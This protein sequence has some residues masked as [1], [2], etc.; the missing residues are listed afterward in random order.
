M[1]IQTTEENALYFNDEE[2]RKKELHYALAHFTMYNFESQKCLNNQ[3][4]N[5]RFRWP[6]FD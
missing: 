4:I 1:R 6:P 3:T 5:S 2:E